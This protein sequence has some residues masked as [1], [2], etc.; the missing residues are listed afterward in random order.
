MAGS[1]SAYM[2]R[3]A[4]S[5]HTTH[6]TTRIK[7][8]QTT[9]YWL[10]HDTMTLCSLFYVVMG[11]TFHVIF[12]SVCRV[13]QN[14]VLTGPLNQ[15]LWPLTQTKGRGV[16][17]AL[18]PGGIQTRDIIKCFGPRVTCE[19][20]RVATWSSNHGWF[21]QLIIDHWMKLNSIMRSVPNPNRSPN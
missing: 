6:N 13:T 1:A 16:K 7:C 18:H 17:K 8:Y 19:T 2:M 4:K 10:L 11:G 12:I 14:D 21:V 3:L 9:S 15:R 5:T 20:S